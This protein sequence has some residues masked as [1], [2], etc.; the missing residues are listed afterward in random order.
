MNSILTH[1]FT[2]GEYAHRRTHTLALAQAAGADAVLSFGENRSGVC[3]TYLTGWAVTRSAA[4]RLTA[5]DSVMWIDF[6]NHVPAARRRAV[7]VDVRAVDDTTSAELLDGL[8]SAATLGPVPPGVRR[9]ADE[10]GVH[11]VAIDPEHA[12]IRARKSPEEQEALRLGAQAS[13]AGARALI[14]A[15]VPGA[16]DWDLLASARSAYTRMGAVEHICYIAVTEMDRPDR[17]VPSQIPEGRT[18]DRGSVVTFELS[19]SVA[20]E[21]PGQV[22]RTVTLGEPTAE[23]REL[24]EVAMQCR[25]AVRQRI[26][27]GVAAMELV[28][29]SAGIE[30]AGMTTT[31]DLFHGLGMG[32]LE[33]IGTSAS[34]EPVRCPAGTLEAGMAIVV[35]PNVTRADHGAGVQTGEMVLVRQNGFEDIHALPEGLVTV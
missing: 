1:S 29:A 13:D 3:V 5:D 33:P 19:A 32:Y 17:D 16:S 15:C 24:H 11:L 18:L 21:Y 14:E 25:A 34:R 10:R 35:Q 31:D 4:H 6:P 28:E 12:L 9:L 7:D 26:R 22:L 30:Q 8:H 23:Y 20:P 2:A 27:A